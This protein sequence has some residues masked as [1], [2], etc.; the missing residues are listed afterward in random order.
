MLQKKVLSFQSSLS[1]VDSGSACFSEPMIFIFHRPFQSALWFLDF[2]EFQKFTKFAFMEKQLKAA[3]FQ[4]DVLTVAPELLGK[5]LVRR[6]EDGSIR[7]Y[8]ITD[9]EA[10]RGEEDKACHAARGRTARTELLYAEGGRIYVYLI[11]GLYWLLNLVTGPEDHP[12]GVMIRAVEGIYGPG[13]VGRELQLS[14]SF[15]G[16]SVENG[17]LW[18]EDR[19]ETPAYIT[20]P[21][22]GI[23][24]AREWKDKPWRFILKEPCETV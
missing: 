11:Y 9:V 7:R 14:A 24:Y 5:Y 10:Y 15:H 6:F 17:R 3:F 4:R 20:A 19:G 1:A 2:L 23:D 16:K 12:Q 13:R 8:R 22:V 21:R 18:L